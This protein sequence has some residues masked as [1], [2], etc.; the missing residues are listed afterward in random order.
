MSNECEWKRREEFLLASYA[1]F[2][3]DTLGRRYDEPLHPHRSPFQRDRDRVLHSAAFRR[4]SGK[5][6]VFTGEMGDYHRTRLTHTHEVATVA[7]TI[8][9][10]LRLNEDLIE[11]LALLHDIGHPPFGHSGEDALSHCLEAKGGFSHNRF[12][13]TLAEQLETRYTTY[14]GLNLSRE[15]LAGQDFR[16]THEG[17]TPLLEVQVVDLSDSIAYNAHDVDDAL[18]LGL[19]RFQQ[20]QGLDLVRRALEWGSAKV[21]AA[22][23]LGLRQALVHSLID[24][25]VVDLL[26]TAGERLQA[27]EG[28]DSLSARQLEVELAQSPVIASERQQ[29]AQFLFENVYRHP[30]LVAI[31]K[32]AAKRVS[33]LFHALVERPQMLPVRFRDLAQRSSVEMATGYYIAGMTDRFCDAQ[34][35]SLIEL[36][37][38]EAVDW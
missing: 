2:A 11:A 34:Y 7:R 24:V 30:D 4:L 38:T 32:L 20:L 14:S 22:S 19:I 17:N 26:E 28:L 31:R 25:Q 3:K 1:M 33:R 18:T 23:E 15:V 36:G 5:M 6:Q 16:I 29:L 12:A 13:L 10:V 37:G 21:H 8:G 35:R 27:I 9:R